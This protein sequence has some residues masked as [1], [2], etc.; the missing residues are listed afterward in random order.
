N[1][2]LGDQRLVRGDDGLAGLQCRLD[3]RQRRLARAAHQFDEAVDVLARCQRHRILRPGDAAE[4]EGALL[5]FRARGDGDDA[6]A[7]ATA[8]GQSPAL[9]LDE[10]DDFG[11]HGAEP[12]NAHFQG[13]HLS[14]TCG[15]IYRRLA[16]GTT[17]CNVSIPLSR[18]RRTPRAAWRIRCSFSTMAMRT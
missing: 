17:L 13:S 5:D 4:V 8:R 10:A 9:V 6:H 14:G 11:T 16:R 15:K 7:T 12:R 3:R 2:V 18:K 1:A